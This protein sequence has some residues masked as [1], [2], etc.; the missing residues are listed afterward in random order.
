M[1]RQ[2]IIQILRKFTKKFEYTKK[3]PITDINDNLIKQGY[4]CKLEITQLLRNA[5]CFTV[6]NQKKPVIM[7]TTD[8][9]ITDNCIVIS[10]CCLNVITNKVFL[11]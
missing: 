10:V 6:T 5:K 11:L 3:K 2:K 4:I 7:I 9:C 1:T 8:N